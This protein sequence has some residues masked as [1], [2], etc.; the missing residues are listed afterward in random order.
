MMNAGLVKTVKFSKPN[1]IGDP[2]NAVKIFNEKE[3][4]EI[5]LLDITS[6]KESYEPNYT[7]IREICSEAFMP[8][9]YG[10]GIHSIEQIKH[11]FDCGIEKI[12]LNTSAFSNPK[13]IE[14]AAS[15]YGS[16]SILVAVDVKKN[17]FG[18]KQV[19][20]KNGTFNTHMKPVE[21]AKKMV[22]AG[23][24][25]IILTSIDSEG[26]CKG[27]DLD[28][29][30]D[31]ASTLEIPLVAH[32]GAGNILHFGEAIKAGASAVA[33]GS[34]FVYHGQTQGILINYPSQALLIDEVYSKIH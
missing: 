3:V 22:N 19:F 18:N 24:G 28:L 2:I 9:A 13:L 34:M 20:V 33:A 14:D 7:K 23:V 6:A 12:I 11:I 32:G 25:E 16:Q 15:I 1:Y 4:D 26:T 8:F 5:V 21:Y 30:N 29:I 17:L 10:G 31:V 27:Y